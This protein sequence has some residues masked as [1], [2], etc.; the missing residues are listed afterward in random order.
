[1][2]SL[3]VN[4][5]QNKL[6]LETDQFGLKKDELWKSPDNFHLLS[7]NCTQGTVWITQEGD[8]E[9]HLLEPG[10]VFETLEEGLVVMQSLSDRSCVSVLHG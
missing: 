3:I 1:M 2:L 9:D 10:E 8:P 4:D 6:H 7:I 5:D